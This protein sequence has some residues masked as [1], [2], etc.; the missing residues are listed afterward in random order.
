MKKVYLLILVVLSLHVNAQLLVSSPNFLNETATSSTIIADGSKGNKALVGNTN[1][2]YVHIG[3]ITNLSTGAS[4]W[5]YVQSTWGT[6]DARFKTVAIG[7]NKWSYTITNNLRSYF[8]ITNA[9][10]K[11]LKIAIL[12]RD[13]AGNTVLRNSDGSDMYVNVYDNNLHVR[14]DTP[15]SQPF[16]VRTLE[17]ITKKLGDTLFVNAKSNLSSNL[18]V[19]YNDTLLTSANNANVVGGYKIINTIGNQKIIVSGTANSVTASDT[20]QFY[21]NGN[22]VLEDLP[23]GIVDGINYLPGDTSVVLVLQAPNKKSIN[24]IGD[25]NN[26][27]VGLSNAMKMTKDSSRFWIQLNGLTSGVEYAYQFVIDGNLK[28]ADY[29]SEKI[30][31]PNN[32]SYIPVTTY[33]NLKAYPTGKTSG[34]VSVLQTAKPKYNWKNTNF[35]RPNKKNLII[36]ELLIRDFT[37]NQNFNELRDSLNYLKKLGINT[38]ELMPVTEFEGNDS[39]GYNT[40]FNFAL[41]K[42]YGTELAF[43]EFID[44]AHAKGIAVVMDMVMNHVFNSSPLAQM[45]WDAT[46]SIPASNNPWLNPTATHPYSV[47]NDF[48]HESPATKLLVSRVVKHWL[49]NYHIDGFRWD[50]S[51][52]FTQKSNPTNVTAWGAYDASRI[53]IWKNIYDTMQKASSNS[54]CILEHFADNSEEIELSNYGMLLWGN[55]NYNFNQATMGYSTNASLNNAF[56]NGRS[57]SQQHL[58]TYMESHDE[59]RL[60]YTNLNYGN[61]NGGYTVR[62][63]ATAL[64]RNEMAAAFWALVPGPKLMWQFGELGYNYSIN[65]CTDL[66]ISNNCRLSDKPLRWEYYNNTNRKGLYD[67]YAK[68]LKLRAQP[69]YTNDF[70]SGKYTL[71]TDGL[72]K[73]VQLNGDSIK[74]V[75]VGNFDVSPLTSN[76]SFPTDGI[77]YSVYTS[78]YQG[79]L[80]GSA[81][82]TLQPGEYIVYANKNIS[83]QVITDI[84]DVNMPVLDMKLNFYP[85]PMQ[86]IGTLEYSLPESGNLLVHAY[87]MQGE[88]VGVL[89]SGYQNKGYQKLSIHKNSL[90]NNPGIY[91]L[92]IQLN[93]KQKIQK[94]LIT[95]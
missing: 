57:W 55:A 31:D 88:D 44:S 60:M 68:F 85:N 92:S 81:S 25:F 8:G 19:L 27:T 43:K 95:N 20:V 30:L 32:D 78:K 56:A 84:L 73:S 76:V 54:Y 47:G 62:D 39:W 82:I 6:A 74:L 72:F 71:N 45:Y 13:A 93:Q 23:T 46:N 53:A 18:S 28:V 24:V 1:D 64:K 91:L 9:S 94:I 42:Y 14:I 11:I 83:T 69:N 35:V 29:N 7:N 67:A 58:V 22:Q 38:I 89:Y 49:N 5:K 70:I 37:K 3:A 4:D 77:W 17:P 2:I 86:N 63:T 65:T 52:G 34:I 16:Y 61:S 15:L 26:W 51:K 87:N 40:S 80:N 48:N 21:V 12:Y 75:I 59:E 79:V 50:L 36:Y 41:D 10:E 90:M 33:P 66:S